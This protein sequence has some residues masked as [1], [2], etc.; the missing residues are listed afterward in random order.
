VAVEVAVPVRG[1]GDELAVVRRRAV[2]AVIAILLLASLAGYALARVLGGR[3]RR[4]A[5][6][7]SKLAGGHLSARAPV[8]APRELATLGESLN[9]M[10]ARLDGLLARTRSERD[11][12]NAL[13]G[14]LAEGVIAVSPAGVVTMANE[15]AQRYL[16]RP[17]GTEAVHLDQLPAAVARAAREVLADR[18][19]AGLTEEVRLA[20]GEVLVLHVAPM[21]DR[22][23]GVVVTMRDVTDERRLEQARRDLVANVSHELK[24]PLSALR[25]FLEL[26]Q[27][28]RLDEDTRREFLELMSHE[29]GRL[30]RLIEE[31]L[32]LARL[33]A[34][35]L[36]LDREA[37][38]LGELAESVVM[39]RRVL[40]G[41]E[42]VDL[43]AS[44]APEAVL[45]DADPARVE[46]ILLI[47]LDNAL[48]HTPAG[49]RIRV[50]VGREGDAGTIAVC[51]TGAGV[52]FEAQPFVFDRF[53]QADP[54]R[55]GRGA[56]LGLAIARGLA[57]AH[58]GGIALRSAPGEG[59]TFTVSLPLGRP[60]PVIAAEAA[61]G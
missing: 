21:D 15:A 29:T 59:S 56:G 26:M 33:D 30:E 24:T 61:R 41:R 20:S 5:R 32:E 51:D 38:D 55:E 12:A 16:A 53:Y 2:L 6:T 28:P 40:A 49:G 19:A 3:I 58:G 23:A 50:V 7:A 57:G 48:S 9:V 36:R 37:V 25:G 46:Q 1:L 31:Q 45:V 18:G 22:A 60:A 10:S 11:R 54:A 27:N 43:S 42:G 17:D 47:L 39:S 44:V 52:P 35:G 4:L 14:S 13:I 34:G 8:P